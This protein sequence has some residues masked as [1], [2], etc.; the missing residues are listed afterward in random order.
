MAEFVASII[1]LAGT[2]VALS[3]SLCNIA[4]AIG[5]AGKEAR[6]VAA[7]VSVFSHSLSELTHQ[8]GK[9]TKASQ[10]L[11]E[12]SLVLKSSCQR[13]LEE[14]RAEIPDD[15]PPCTS[16]R[17]AAAVKYLRVRMTWLLKKPKVLFLRQSMESFKMTLVLLVA[18]MNYSE[19]S[20][21]EAPATIT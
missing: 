17:D 10:R 7:E 19:A 15:V 5:S 14:L 4:D 2:G 8:L 11:S 18:T 3:R 12:I 9:P 1:A 16:F 21:S 13:V 6:L 20:C